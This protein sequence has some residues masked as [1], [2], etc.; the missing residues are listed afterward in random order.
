PVFYQLTIGEQA[1]SFTNVQQLANTIAKAHSILNATKA[2]IG[3]AERPIL[4]NQADPE[5]Q[6]LPS[7]QHF[8]CHFDPRHSTNQSQDRYGDRTLSTDCYPQNSAPP[9]NKFVSFQLQPLDKPPQ[10]QLRTEKLLEQ[11]I[12]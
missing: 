4:F 7:P 1:K 2:E 11:L 3:I 6:P 10:P 9:P 12:Q 8:N 5:I